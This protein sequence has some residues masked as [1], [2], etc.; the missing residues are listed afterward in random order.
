KRGTETHTATVKALLSDDASKAVRKSSEY[1]ARTTMQYLNDQ[2]NT[3]WHPSQAREHT[4][5]IG[6]PSEPLAEEKP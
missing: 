6:N 3:G 5:T 1:Q 4:I 2:L